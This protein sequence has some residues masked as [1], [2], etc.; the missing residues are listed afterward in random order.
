MY[1]QPSLSKIVVAEKAK[2]HEKLR[3]E[4]YYEEHGHPI[5]NAEKRFFQIVEQKRKERES[6]YSELRDQFY[7]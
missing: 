6:I 4:E 2:E 3:E 7:S 5:A 1:I